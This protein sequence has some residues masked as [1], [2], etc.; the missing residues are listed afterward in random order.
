MRREERECYLDVSSERD[1]RGD[2]DALTAARNPL[3]FSGDNERSFLVPQQRKSSA[4][5]DSGLVVLLADACTAV[6]VVLLARQ[7]LHTWKRGFLFAT[8]EDH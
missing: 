8:I 6:S 5:K 3:A 2:G 4:H 7:E 1:D